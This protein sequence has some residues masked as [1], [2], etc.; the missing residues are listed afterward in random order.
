MEMKILKF[1]KGHQGQGQDQGNKAM[2]SNDSVKFQAWFSLPLLWFIILTFL[3][4][5]GLLLP[6][7]IL[8]DDLLDHILEVDIK[9]R[10]VWIVAIFILK[11]NLLD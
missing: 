7:D 1:M 10:Y 8:V 11:D 5:F 3:H 9:R 6:D 4:L 2:V